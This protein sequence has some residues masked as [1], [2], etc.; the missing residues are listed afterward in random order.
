MSKY[1]V[2]FIATRLTTIKI[3]YSKL[4]NT[5]VTHNYIVNIAGN[6]EACDADAEFDNIREQYI[7]KLRINRKLMSIY[8]L[9]SIIE[10]HKLILKTKPRI[11][12]VT[13]PIAAALLRVCPINFAKLN[14]NIIYAA[15]GFHFYKGSPIFN[16]LVY[17]PIEYILSQKTNH[18]ITTNNEDYYLAKKYFNSSLIHKIS[19]V[20]L[21][22]HDFKARIKKT[23]YTSK[24][25][26]TEY[27]QKIII[28]VGELNSNKNHI[29]LIPYLSTDN[30]KNIH[31]VICGKG[32][33]AKDLE[34]HARK[35]GVSDRVH[36]L[37][38]RDDIH[39]LLSGSDLFF[40]P[41]IREGFGMSLVEAIAMNVDFVASKIRGVIDIVPPKNHDN[42]LFEVGDHERMNL[43]ILDKLNNG[44][45]YSVSHY[46]NHNISIEAVN[47]AYLEIIGKICNE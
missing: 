6:F 20:G 41:S 33:L 16:W 43:L 30:F 35:Y 27:D 22:F 3:F 11:I 19:G 39:K 15:H 2:M 42:H 46:L 47:S 31:Y 24:I 9:F 12:L 25:I 40:F 37:G 45:I 10:I 4:I 28:S 23:A 44:N 8:N 14:I 34:N 17:F 29:S 38:Y 13:T 26:R 21:N 1:N 18:I 36:L 32:K 7:H 5:L